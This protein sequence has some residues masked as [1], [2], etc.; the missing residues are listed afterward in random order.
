MQI[1][2]ELRALRAAVLALGIASLLLTGCDGAS[3]DSI[4]QAVAAVHDLFSPPTKDAPASAYARARSDGSAPAPTPA[5]APA[6]EEPTS[7]AMGAASNE[8]VAQTGERSMDSVA[9]ENAIRVYYQFIDD[10]GVVRFVERLTDVP[11]AWRDRVGYIEMSTPPPLT[12]AEARKSW[13]ADPDAVHRKSIE[14]ASLGNARNPNHGPSLI[15][16]SADWCGYCQQAKRHLDGAG[17]SYDERNVDIPAVAQELREK[18]G[19]GGVPVL[20][21]DGEVLRGYRKDQYDRFLR[22]L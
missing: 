18:T 16:Y 17:F 15:L 5:D 2:V 22:D 20:D 1:R 7:T 21:A 3:G 13:K 6:P 19:R 8:A 14:L 12:P 10:R 9:P 11:S 4:A